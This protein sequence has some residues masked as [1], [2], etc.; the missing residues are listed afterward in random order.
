[1]KI[2]SKKKT[3]QRTTSAAATKWPMCLTA[4][5]MCPVRFLVSAKSRLL[6]AGWQSEEWILLFL[7]GAVTSA[8]ALPVCAIASS[9]F[10]LFTMIIPAAALAMPR[11]ITLNSVESLHYC[12]SHYYVLRVMI[13]DFNIN[14]LEL[15]HLEMRLRHMIGPVSTWI[16]DRTFS[17][18][19]RASF[20]FTFVLCSWIIF[21]KLHAF[22]LT[23]DWPNLIGYNISYF[24]TNALY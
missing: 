18:S 16:F 19:F 24:Y 14:L 12:S 5:S 8:L 6:A 17:F 22:S 9:L 23:F 3:L 15:Q 1:M 4:A 13:D 21:S 11:V 7:F 2:T 20:I 10:I